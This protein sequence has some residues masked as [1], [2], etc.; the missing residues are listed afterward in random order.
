MAF[1]KSYFIEHVYFINYLIWQIF[2]AK[3]THPINCATVGPD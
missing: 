2:F 1:Y 3:Y